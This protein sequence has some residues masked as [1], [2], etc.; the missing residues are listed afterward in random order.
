MAIDLSTNQ[1]KALRRAAANSDYHLLLGAGAS[2]DAVAR[3]GS[4]L[5]TGPE[6]ATL[7]SDQFKVP[8]EEGDLLWRVY[9]RAVEDAGE[10]AVYDWL[11]SRFWGVT[12]PGWMDVY[13]RAPWASVWTLNVDDVFEQAYARVRSDVSRSLVTVNWDDEFRQSHDLAVVH[14]H[15][16]VDRDAMRHLIFSLSQYAGSAVAQAAW[17]LNFRDTYGV[18]PF[19][20]IGARLRDEPDIETVI[21]NRTPTHEAPSFYVSPNI[22]SA[23]ERDLHAWNL[24]PVRMTAEEFAEAWP[25]LTE[26]NLKK[27]PTRREEVAFRIGRQFR[28]LRI[29][30]VRKASRDH[31]FIGGDEP[32]WIDIRNGLN[33]DLDWIRQASSD[34]RQLGRTARVNS[35]MIYV[36]NRLT[37]RSTGLLAISKALRKLSWRTYL[38]VGDERPDVEAI[39]QFAANGQAIALLFDSV[40]DIAD[41]VASILSLARNASLQIV[42][43]AVDQV[44]RSAN[45]LGRLDEAYL[46][47]NRVTTINTHLTNTDAAHLV[48]KLQSIGRLGILELERKD[49]RRR[50]HFRGRELF[51]AMAQLENAP[52][53]GRR[54]RELV[55]A[56]SD[57]DHIRVLFLAA[58]ASRFDC[59][60][61]AV[62]AARMVG[63]ESDSLV[64]LVRDYPP[65]SS[66]LKTDGT[67]IRPRQRWMALDACVERLGS[68]DALATLGTAMNNVAPRLGRSS[69]RERNATSLLVAAFMTYKNVVSVFPEADLDQWYG[70]LSGTFGDWSAR[71]WEQRAIMNRHAGKSMPEAWARA[72]SFA[73]RAVSIVRDSYSLTTLGT[74]LLAKAAFGPGVD[75]GQYYDRA[76]DAY[77]DASEANPKNLVTWLAFLRHALNVLAPD[78][79]SLRP[80]PEEVTERMRDDWTRI[81]SQSLIAAGASEDVKGEL[82]VLKRRFEKLTRAPSTLG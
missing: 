13:A 66:V 47:R 49:A 3:D 43:V 71:Y 22:S 5:P 46:L 78:G 67:W 72:E 10:R 16:C 62:D 1:K 51:D 11:K 58:L 7:L 33:A 37:G 30:S 56:I 74:V 82:A 21:A 48:D 39:I 76:I 70:G 8:I 14:L 41:D 4:K 6:L 53:F 42:C 69:H 18:S 2:R 79:R 75:V 63:M 17:P 26:I 31:D 40:A 54:V 64:R 44:D 25:E 19:V 35:A 36:G 68:R 57:L 59:R 50:S 20:I 23:V 28:E 9:A 32:E 61:H 52:G 73:L 77:E 12:P 80:L 81:H 15:G 29:D 38:Y 27:A 34:C 60:F 55:D 24:V 65:I 45:I